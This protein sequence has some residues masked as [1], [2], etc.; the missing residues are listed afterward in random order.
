MLRNFK[1]EII[2]AIVE[3]FLQISVRRSLSRGKNSFSIVESLIC[4]AKVAIF[5]ELSRVFFVTRRKTVLPLSW[6]PRKCHNCHEMRSLSTVRTNFLQRFLFLMA[7][8]W[9]PFSELLRISRRAHYFPIKVA[10][11][12][13]DSFFHFLSI[14]IWFQLSCIPPTGSFAFKL[15]RIKKS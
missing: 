1:E 14:L 9:S 8:S 12:I 13:S 11:T 4:F 10:R 5:C 15:H 7:L 2:A 3:L 6:T